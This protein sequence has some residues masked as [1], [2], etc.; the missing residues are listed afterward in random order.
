LVYCSGPETTWNLYWSKG[1]SI[2][3]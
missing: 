1:W 2:N 3:W